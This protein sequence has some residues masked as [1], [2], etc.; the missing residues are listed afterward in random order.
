MA[1]WIMIILTTLVS[2]VA[3]S[4]PELMVKLQFNAAEIIHR[5]QYYR[6]LSHAFVHAGW[7]HLL[8]NMM[9]LYFFGVP[10]ES[11]LG[12]YFGNKGA[13]LF[14]LLYGGGLLMSNLWS[15]IRHRNIPGRSSIFSALSPSP[16]FF[17]QP[18][19][20]FIRGIKAKTSPTI[21]PTMPIF[22]E[23]STDLYFRYF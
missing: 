8:V 5:K 2:Y 11:F 23:L 22:W 16:V 13:A 18:D 3:F 6:L 10:V 9:V 20:L 1:T 17:L 7:T 21:S 4:K 15:L 19:T 12:L 14:L